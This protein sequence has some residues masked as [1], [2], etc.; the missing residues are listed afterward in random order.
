L[1]HKRFSR[2]KRTARIR[3]QKKRKE[4]LN[5]QKKQEWRAEKAAGLHM[6]ILNEG[7]KGEFFKT[8]K[9]EGFF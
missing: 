4:A 6:R 2:E 7:E 3:L 5:W 9:S 1:V 8:V